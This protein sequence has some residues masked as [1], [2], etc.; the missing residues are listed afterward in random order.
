[1][2]QAFTELEP[3]DGINHGSIILRPTS[4]KD[5]DRNKVQPKASLPLVVELACHSNDIGIDRS[6]TVLSFQQIV[7][8]ARHRLSVIT[9]Q[10][11]AS[12]DRGSYNNRN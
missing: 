7:A 11:L 10:D 12:L 9:A 2:V 3:S 5:C 1:M 6:G 8:K 4:G